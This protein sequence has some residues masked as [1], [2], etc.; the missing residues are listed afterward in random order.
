MNILIKLQPLYL[1]FVGIQERGKGKTCN[2][3]LAGVVVF[4]GVMFDCRWG[5]GEVGLILTRRVEVKSASGESNYASR[6]I[7]MVVL[8]IYQHV[9]YRVGLETREAH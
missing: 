2:G 1:G 4:F 9:W 7:V 8:V 3:Y 5:K 6:R